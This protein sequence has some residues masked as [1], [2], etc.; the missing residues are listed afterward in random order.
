MAIANNPDRLARDEADIL[1]VLK[2]AGGDLIPEE[3]ESLDM[4]RLQRFAERFGQAERLNGYIKKVKGK[5]PK[6]TRTFVL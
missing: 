3:F 2:L 6:E 4:D 5:R 1:A